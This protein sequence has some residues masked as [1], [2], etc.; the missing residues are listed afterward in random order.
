MGLP[1]NARFGSIIRPKILISIAIK[2]LL[3]K[4][5]RTLLTIG[6]ITIGVGAIVFLVSLADG[7]R[8]VVTNQVIGSSSVKTIDVTS[9]NVL[10]IPLDVDRVDKMKAIANVNEVAPAYIMPGKISEQGS[11]AD[12]VLYGTS[13][14]YMNLIG[15]Q[16]AAGS[17]QLSGERDAVISASLLSL[18]GEEDA[19]SAIGK[20]I[21][22]SATITL[23]GGVEKEFEEDLT[24]VGVATLT[25][26]VAIYMQEQ[27]LRDG[28]AYEYGQV[29]VVANDQEDV[30]VIRGQI[31]SLG[32]TTASPLDTL[33]EINT[34]FTIFTFVVIG[35]GGIGM[36]IAILG[37]FNTLTISLLERTSEI[38]LMVTMGARRADVQRLLIFEALILSL[39]GGIS[40]IISAWLIGLGV[41]YGLTYFAGGRGVEGAINAF[42]VTPVLVLTTVAFTLIIGLLVALYPARRAAKINP[43]DALR[44]E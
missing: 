13:N 44:H 7:L 34:I 39:A 10:T 5:L 33:D 16:N 9:P 20:Q 28:G 43:I 22:V 23:P 15:L 35:F 14:E 2:N 1:K 40:G 24:I 29:K 6:G 31:S 32:L 12:A 26:G 8:G 36:I 25:S 38:G 37:M 11:L 41:N 19:N 3:S 21:A 17:S 4:R 18:I 27:L 30:P 42:T